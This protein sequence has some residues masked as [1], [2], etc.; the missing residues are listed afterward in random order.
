LEVAHLLHGHHDL[1]HLVVEVP[2]LAAGDDVADAGFHK[3]V[4]DPC[5]LEGLGA[6]EP[7]EVPADDA[8]EGAA[9]NSAWAN[10]ISFCR[11][12]R[13]SILRPGT[14]SSVNGSPTRTYLSL[15]AASSE[16]IQVI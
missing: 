10:A 5:R 8:V 13:E 11:P 3:V 9:R 2:D 7:V 4:E 12:G 16:S 1:F 15:L 6:G 14:P